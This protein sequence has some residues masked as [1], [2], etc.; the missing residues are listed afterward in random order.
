MDLQI[1]IR[2]YN[3]NFDRNLNAVTQIEQRLLRQ[4][5]KLVEFPTYCYTMTD[6]KKPM[7][8]NRQNLFQQQRDLSESYLSQMVLGEVSA[9]FTEEQDSQVL[10]FLN[11][12]KKIIELNVDVTRDKLSLSSFKN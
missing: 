3:T 7:H 11:G 2:P 1:D 8:A 6:I 9:Q 10:K 5:S 4:M 12:H